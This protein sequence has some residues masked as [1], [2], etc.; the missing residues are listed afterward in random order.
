MKGLQRAIDYVEEH[1]T[2]P[3]DYEK[4]AKQA[5]LSSFHFQR[6]FSI[7]CDFTLGD[8]IR[9]WRPSLAGNELA[10]S[11]IRV[12]DAAMKYAYD[13]PENFSRAFT[14]MESLPPRQS[15]PAQPSISFFRFK[16][17][18]NNRYT[19][20]FPNKNYGTSGSWELKASPFPVTKNRRNA[21]K[22]F[23]CFPSVI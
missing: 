21:D 6:V 9:M 23:S 22:R 8:Y 13:M 18:L 16:S 14:R 17:D 11:G 7:V 5:Y 4:V 15:V 10:S 19:P 3:I 12:I 1:I 2:E 20:I